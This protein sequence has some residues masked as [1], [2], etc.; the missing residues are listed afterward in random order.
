MED[1]RRKHVN[2]GM[3]VLA[4]LAIGILFVS[5]APAIA[6]DKDQV[7]GLV[8]KARITFNDFMHDS[9]YVWLHENID[10]AK[11]ILIFPQVIK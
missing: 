2:V 10:H 11:G 6:K 7:Q 9:N 8:D 3:L 4:F 5:Y 1:R